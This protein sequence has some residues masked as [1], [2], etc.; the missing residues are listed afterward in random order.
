[1]VLESPAEEWPITYT[2]T[3]TD[4]SVEILLEH[5]RRKLLQFE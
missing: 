2:Y 5:F 1:M 3:Y 4:M